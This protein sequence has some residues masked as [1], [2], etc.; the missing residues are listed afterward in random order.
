MAPADADVPAG[1]AW[2]V[3]GTSGRVRDRPRPTVTSPAPPRDPAQPPGWRAGPAATC[4]RPVAHHV[5]RRPHRAW[6]ASAGREVGPAPGSHGHVG[7]AGVVR[8]GATSPSPCSTRRTTSAAARC[9]R[10]V[11]GDWRAE[12]ILDRLGLA[13][14]L[15]QD[16][17]PVSG[18]QRKRGRLAPVHRVRPASSTSPPTT[19][20]SRPSP[21]S[22]SG[23]PTGRP[24]AGHPRPPRARPRHEPGARDRPQRL[25]RARRRVRRAPGGTGG[26]G[27]APQ[28]AEAVRAN[29]A[30]REAGL[31]GGGP[32]ARTRKSKHPGGPG[33]GPAGRPP[34]TCAPRTSTCTRA[35]P[36]WASR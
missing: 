19:S 27:C 2:L 33:R 36:A 7:Q 17:A 18:G 4:S 5:E 14:V 1:A 13:P 25:V 34:T 15:G 22:R 11:G 26:P 21:G 29:L 16:V 23:S 6:S 9:A 35:R 31:A 24:P 32:P 10:V 8:R 12:A 20:T 30:K 3:Q 28:A